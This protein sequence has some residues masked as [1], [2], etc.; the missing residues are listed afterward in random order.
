[1]SFKFIISMAFLQAIGIITCI[2]YA[3]PLIPIIFLT[4]SVVG[5][6]L[7][8]FFKIVE[9]KEKKKGGK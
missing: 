7:A 6:T 1:M 3:T 5:T 8:L 4:I 9:H 2:V